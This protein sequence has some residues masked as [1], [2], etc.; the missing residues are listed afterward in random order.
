MFLRDNGGFGGQHNEILLDCECGD[1]IFINSYRG[2]VHE[3]YI[4]PNSILHHKG[5]GKTDH[6]DLKQQEVW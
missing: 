1:T 5:N 3:P 6:I 4:Q 2:N